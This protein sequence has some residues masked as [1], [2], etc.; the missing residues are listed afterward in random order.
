[1]LRVVALLL[2]LFALSNGPALSETYYVAPLDAVVSGTP[3]GTEG[4]PFLSIDKAFASGKVKG[5][6]TLLLKD[7]A[8]GP[9]TIKANAAF[10]KPVVIM[11]QNAKAAHFDSILL[12]QTTRNLILRNLSVWPRDPTVGF[13]APTG[14]LY[15]V[16]AYTTTSDI[17]LD[18]LDIRSEKGAAEYMKWDAERWNARKFSGVLLQGARSLVTRSRL[19]GVYS[20]VEVGYDSQIVDN[21]IDGFNG[22][23]MRA[24]SRSIVR[25]N[26]VFNCVNTDANHD[27][28]FQSWAINGVPVTGL[29]LDSNVIIEWMGSPDH[30]LR[31]SLQ[32]IGLFDGIYE[33]LTIM[34]N[35]IST[36][37]YHGISVYGA[38]GARIANNTVVH[39]KGHTLT[40][41]YIAVRPHKNG[42]PSTDVLV[43]NN[44]A[45]SFQGTVS[46]TDRVE[47]RNNS[48][49]GTPSLV[50][51][52]PV[53][54][55]YRPKASSGFI[56][57]GDATV[58]P[59]TDVMGQ[60]R[61]SGPLPDRGAYEVQVGGPP[62]DTGAVSYTHLTLPTSDLV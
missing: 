10:D 55:D 60:K 5:G 46:A 19:T 34:N 40:Y 4:L 57:T 11:S 32:G 43:A 7:G 2:G 37:H 14:T 18:G 33:N 51:E 61:P 12:A 8:Y 23:G 35:L 56:D 29:V 59:A 38:R 49:I 47:F 15:L 31:C 25:G 58:A 22:D 6:D 50:F 20:G 16:R 62:V 24:F 39:L 45:M 17:T 28:G 54:F 9:V 26:R 27:D 41:P 53:A 36:T 42:T 13:G 44:I 48:V 1:M 21:V 52:N 30:P 3:D